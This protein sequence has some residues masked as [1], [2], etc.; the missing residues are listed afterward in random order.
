MIA[1]LGADYVVTDSSTSF[2]MLNNLTYQFYLFIFPN[3]LMLSIGGV[4]LLITVQVV[5]KVR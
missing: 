5:S 3:L 2:C 4:L 1:L